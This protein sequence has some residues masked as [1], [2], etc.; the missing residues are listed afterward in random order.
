[1][2]EIDLSKEIQEFYEQNKDNNL[3]LSKDEIIK[4]SKSRWNI[5][6]NGWSHTELFKKGVKKGVFGFKN[7]CIIFTNNSVIFEG[8]GSGF[9]RNKL[10]E[11]TFDN[12]NLKVD[13]IS[14]HPVL[15]LGLGGNKITF[16]LNLKKTKK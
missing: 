6:Y 4:K 16:N 11:C 13:I 3:L 9:S 7:H 2:E 15:E 10:I 12:I 5:V 1:M 8:E 14:E